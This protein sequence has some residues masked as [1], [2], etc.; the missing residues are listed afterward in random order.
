MTDCLLF[1]LIGNEEER[2]QTSSTSYPPAASIPTHAV[3]N[4]SEYRSLGNIHS[5]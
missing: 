2:N 3:F 1:T 4:K 5:R